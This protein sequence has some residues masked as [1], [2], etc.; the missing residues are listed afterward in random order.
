MEDMAIVNPAS[1]FGSVPRSRASITK[2]H[3]T[4]TPPQVVG[5]WPESI[6][7]A[8]NRRATCVTIYP[9]PDNYYCLP[10][11]LLTGYA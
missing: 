9:V 1:L 4:H 5:I 6:A 11:Q 7:A 8:Q 2:M 10:E 3:I